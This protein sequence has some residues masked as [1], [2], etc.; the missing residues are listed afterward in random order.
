[1]QEVAQELQATKLAQDGVIEAQRQSFQIELERVREKLQEVELKSRSLEDEI[2]TLKGRDK[3]PE[4][5]PA[6]NTSV[7]EKAQTV[8]SSS[9]GTNKKKATDPPPK[10]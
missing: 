6:P 7:A 5:G 3:A 10:S 1:M 2:K 8:P 9:K 4:C